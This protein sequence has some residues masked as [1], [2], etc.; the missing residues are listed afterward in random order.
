MAERKD[1]EAHRRQWQ[2]RPEQRELDLA[3]GFMVRQAATLEFFLHQA[4]RRLVGGQHA[5]LVTAGMQAS[6]LLDAIKRIIDVGA[7]S[8]EAA[9]EMTEISGKCRIAFKE[10]NRFV[11]GIR[12]IGAENSEAWTN[13]RRNGSIDQH[14]IEAEQLME[15]GSDFARLSSQLS[16]W[17]RHYLDGHPRRASR[18]PS[19]P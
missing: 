6:S 18:P 1:I 8:D 4:V 10:R 5:I 7:V 11:H 14:P 19:S 17:Y 3:L 2:V 12:V 15:L 16:D 13:N 9:Q